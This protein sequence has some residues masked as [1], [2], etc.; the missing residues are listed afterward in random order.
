MAWDESTKATYYF[1]K[2]K[3]IQSNGLIKLK[4]SMC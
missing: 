4:I 1:R 2:R 3:V